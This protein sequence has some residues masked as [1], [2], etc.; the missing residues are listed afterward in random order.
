[1][2]HGFIWPRI[3]RAVLE[4]EV[5]QSL[6]RPLRFQEV[7]AFRLPDNQHMTAVTSAIRI[8]RLYPQEIFLI[9]IS[10]RG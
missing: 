1:V 2:R 7:E 3:W 10:I 8:G 5:K 6:D 9:L 4:V